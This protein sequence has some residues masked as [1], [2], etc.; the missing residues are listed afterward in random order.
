MPGMKE[1][2]QSKPTKRESAKDIFRVVLRAPNRKSLN[3]LLLENPLDLGR[4]QSHPDAEE[5][6]VDVFVNKEQ[7]A[8]L[9]K[10]GWKLDIHENLSEVGRRRQ[11]EVGKGDRFKG[12][13]KP[14]KG[15]GKKT[16]KEG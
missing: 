11:Q 4:I 15:L 3:E 9:K 7:I 14:P 5:L 2:T 13:K 8:Q 12:G 1:P 10:T 6:T 16:G